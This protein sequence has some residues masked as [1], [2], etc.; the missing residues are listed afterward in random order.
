MFY[1]IK[2]KIYKH[3]GINITILISAVLVVLGF[4][5]LYFV[6]STV[7]GIV[8]KDSGAKEYRNLSMECQKL[9]KE[10]LGLVGSI[11]ME[12]AVS[13]GFVE[14]ENADFI[15]RKKNYAINKGLPSNY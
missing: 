7:A 15:P 13:K 12:Y 5:Y 11:D 14:K 6:N 9:E 2:K 3:F 10:Y 8:G 1:I 4:S